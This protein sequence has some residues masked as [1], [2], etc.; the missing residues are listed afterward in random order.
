[1]FAFFFREKAFFLQGPMADNS[2]TNRIRPA[3]VNG[4]FHLFPSWVE[5]LLLFCCWLK[6]NVLESPSDKWRFSD[7]VPI[8]CVATG[9]FDRYVNCT[10]CSD[11]LRSNFFG[12][13]LFWV[14]FVWKRRLEISLRFLLQFL[15][16]PFTLFFSQFVLSLNLW[17][18]NTFSFSYIYSFIYY[19][20]FL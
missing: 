9:Y 3:P 18:L 8:R 15:F 14:V 11:C 7:C 6:G 20:I 12:C 13:Q 5:F 17:L 2:I 4:Q 1:M 16:L 19:N 10:S